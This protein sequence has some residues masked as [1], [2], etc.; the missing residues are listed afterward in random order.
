MP[1]PLGQVVP[2]PSPRFMLELEKRRRILV[3]KELPA[4]H[5]PA[6]DRAA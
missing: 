4:D 3:G 6:E 1:A 2:D 5:A